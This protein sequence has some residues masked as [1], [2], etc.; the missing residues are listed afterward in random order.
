MYWGVEVYHHALLILA[1]VQ[2]SLIDKSLVSIGRK[3]VWVSEPDWTVAN[4]MY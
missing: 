2:A 1:L 4:V 3:A